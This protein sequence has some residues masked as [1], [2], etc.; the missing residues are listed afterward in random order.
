M[1][2]IGSGVRPELGRTN[3]GG[4]LAGAQQGSAAIGRGIEKVG[5]G[6]GDM[7]KRQKDAEKETQASQKM[8]EAMAGVY[9]EESKIGQMSAEMAMN[10]ADK[11]IPLSQRN[12]A[13]SSGSQIMGMML[14]KAEQDVSNQYRERQMKVAEGGLGVQQTES[15]ARMSAIRQKMEAEAETKT[16]AGAEVRPIN[17]PTNLPPFHSFRRHSTNGTRISSERFLIRLLLVGGCGAKSL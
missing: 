15:K 17:Q 14:H 7:M 4:F 13:A 10:L 3:Y 1:A 5:A 9:G 11:D 16:E 2:R 12:A 8:F 6:V